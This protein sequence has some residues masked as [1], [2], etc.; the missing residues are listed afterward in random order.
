MSEGRKITSTSVSPVVHVCSDPAE[1]LAE[2]LV[3]DITRYE[4]DFHLAVSGG[5]TPE[6]L[7]KLLALKY[8]DLSIWGR[9]YLYQVDERCVSP[10]HEASNWRMIHET[11]LAKVPQ[12]KAFR[13]EAERDDAAERYEHLLRRH[14]PLTDYGIPRLDC[15]LL[16]M[17]PDG[18]TASLF[19]RAAACQEEI[20]LVVNTEGPEG[21]VPR[22]TMTFPT[23]ENANVRRFLVVGQDKSEALRRVFEG[24][25]LPA[26]RLAKISEWFL[27]PAASRLLQLRQ[28]TS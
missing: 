24:E 20:R 18:H 28:D 16:G 21:G 15:V 5:R 27:D 25:P 1:R 14:V 8:G 4:G 9:V 11:L 6:T 13:M 10:D 26:Q 2:A 7:F 23:L 12:I 19:P 22:V 3:S 17:G